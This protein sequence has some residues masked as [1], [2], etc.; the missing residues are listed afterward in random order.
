M[1][2]EEGAV[3]IIL[4][5]KAYALFSVFLSV[6]KETFI[7]YAD[8]VVHDRAFGEWL[9]VNK[10]KINKIRVVDD[11]LLHGNALRNCLEMLRARGYDNDK[12]A[13]YI[14]A[15]NEQLAD[16]KF[17]RN[18]N[19]SKEKQR[20]LLLL[21]EG[22]A[23]TKGANISEDKLYTGELCNCYDGCFD[24]SSSDAASTYK[25]YYNRKVERKESRRLAR[26]FVEAIH[27]SS[28]PYIANMP[29]YSLDFTQAANLLFDKSVFPDKK[30]LYTTVFRHE[31]VSKISYSLNSAF[32]SG[33]MHGVHS[34]CS[35]LNAEYF[36]AKYEQAPMVRIYANY[37]L[38]KV[39]IIPCSLFK[40]YTSS[41]L[42]FNDFPESIRKYLHDDS[43]KI[44]MQDNHK[45]LLR[46]LHYGRAMEIMEFLFGDILDV[47]KLNTI[48]QPFFSSEASNIKALWESMKPA[49]S[50]KIIFNW[51]NGTGEKCAAAYADDDAAKRLS[52]YTIPGIFQKGVLL[53]KQSYDVYFDSLSNIYRRTKGVSLA[54]F[55]ETISKR[56]EQ[57]QRYQRSSAKQL[58]LDGLRMIA[59]A[60]SSVLCDRGVG[61]PTINVVAPEGANY[62]SV[63]LRLCDG[64]MSSEAFAK[65]PGLACMPSVVYNI[66]MVCPKRKWNP[67]RSKRIAGIKR[68]LYDKIQEKLNDESFTPFVDHFFHEVSDYEFGDYL[69]QP[70]GCYICGKR[71]TKEQML[72]HDIESEF[73]EKIYNDYYKPPQTMN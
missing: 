66:H 16:R 41:I 49:L 8:R 56:L 21:K 44:I 4:A 59:H 19:V 37:V 50:N 67:S 47:S 62:Y 11:T 68:D 60:F 23:V 42:H 2:K 34:L 29:V 18:I 51:N 52:K 72:F 31:L 69:I 26:Q 58:N 12:V 46:I 39:L 48:K 1:P 6:E 30:D 43:S 5:R 25:V 7:Q 71:P 54:Y 65:V 55:I 24:E 32:E 3:T 38:E 10:E 61:I 14:F 73:I 36:N 33:E 70:K 53:H 63:G 35:V 27:A 17:V 15:I 13:A 28:N 45:T 22:K 57:R 9:S 20:T 40:S 64:E